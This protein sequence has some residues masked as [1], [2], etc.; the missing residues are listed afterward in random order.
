[1][2]LYELHLFLVSASSHHRLHAPFDDYVPFLSQRYL[3]E[4]IPL[5]PPAFRLSLAFDHA[6]I[7]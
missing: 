2:L 5:I 7:L 4:H 6:G 1:M 3:F